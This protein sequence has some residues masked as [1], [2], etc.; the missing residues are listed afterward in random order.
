MSG[1][2]TATIALIIACSLW[3]S[4]FVALKCSFEYFDP[5]VVIFGRLFV[6]SICFLLIGKRF[7]KQN[8]RPGDWKLILLMGLC[9]PGLYF[10]FEAIGLT[11]TDASQAGMICA[12]MPLLVGVAARIFL[13]ERISRRSLTGFSLAIVG[14]I[15]LS[16]AAQSSE[17]APNPVLGNSLEFLAMLCATGYMI[18]LKHLTPRYSPWFLTMMQAFIGTLFFLP[19]LFLPTTQLPT[20][21]P[22]EGVGYVLFMG[23]CVTITAYGLYNYGIS[24]IPASQASAFINLIPVISLA[25]GVILLGEKLNAIQYVASGLVLGGVWLSQD[26][27]KVGQPLEESKTAA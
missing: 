6:A 17:S 25:L 8:Y 9:E 11:Y 18:I 23:I 3:G 4:S 24:K 26:K 1:K 10:V 20:S 7:G 15:V 2:G 14:A 16:A 22:I 19:I 12:L 5:M 21:L 27:K 13:N